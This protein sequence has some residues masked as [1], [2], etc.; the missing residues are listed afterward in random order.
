MRLRSLIASLFL[1]FSTCTVSAADVALVD[2][3]LGQAL[4][5]SNRGLCYAVLPNHISAERDRIALAVPLPAQQGSAQIFWRDE[6]NDLAL[7]FV[8]GELAARCQ[9]TL[10]SLSGDL[11]PT[12]IGAESGLIKSV[13]F[14]GQFFDRLTATVV[15][16]DDDFARIRLTEGGV[17]GQVMQGLSGAMLSVNERIAGI[18]IDADASG[19]AR[20]LRM[21][22]IAAIIA[23]PLNGAQHPQTQVISETGAHGGKGY[24][25]TG[26]QGGQNAEIVSLEAG[27]SGAAWSAP[28]TGQAVEFEITLSNDALVSV[29]RIAMRT[30]V[31]TEAGPP[32]Q[33]TISVDRGLP[34]SAYWTPLVAPDM[35]PTGY[36]D[37]ATG[38]TV[39]R[40]IRVRIVDV[41]DTSKNVRIDGLL[42]Q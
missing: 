33:L 28:W 37:L 40:R 23:E 29:N 25:F 9:V 6:S 12:L 13:H 18:A 36:F 1:A 17:D 8:E 11:S 35:S 20:F 38:G 42:V 15:D 39:A 16:V 24:R 32:R 34:G 26:F 2:A 5:I 41:W 7:A 30:V 4:L 14:D 21:D 3:D 19:A 10:Q 31:G 27:G 22:R